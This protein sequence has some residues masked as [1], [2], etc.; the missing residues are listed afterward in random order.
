MLTVPLVIEKIYKNKILPN[1]QKNLLI[2][3]LYAIPFVR[4]K[5]NKIAGKKLIETFGGNI[6]F[7]GVG[8][9]G[10]SPTVEKF[11]REAEFPYCIGY[12]LTETAPF[13]AGTT[14]DKTKL[15]AIGPVIP[16]AE[17][18]LRD[19][20][21]KGIGTLWARG[22]NVMMGY[23]KDP[24]KTAEVIDENGWFNTEDIGYLDEEGYFFM[25]GRA[26]NII[27]GSSG[28]NIYPEQIEAAINAQTFVADS[29]VYDDKGILT[30]RIHLDY[31]KLDEILGVSEKSETKMHAKVDDLL[32]KIRLEVNE[33]ISAF[34]R[35]RKVI[36]QREP[37][38]KTPTK[39]IK[40]YLY[41]EAQ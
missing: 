25:S 40:R 22:P 19:Q 36:E 37:F 34:S 6:R 28:E 38:I 30:A 29:L 21:A 32:E 39:K 31:D 17:L 7:F 9:A 11:L 8:G 1:F 14:P 18:E 3:M 13:L 16:G 26:K 33:N 15:K 27:I 41:V 5:L 35:I 10:L 20:D 2:K 23:Y 12:G 24:E 4:K